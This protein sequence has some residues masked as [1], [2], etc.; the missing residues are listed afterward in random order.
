ML[1]IIIP[2]AGRGSRFAVAGYSDPKPL[3]PIN[4]TPMIQVVINNLRPVRPHRFIFIC[5][6]DH[7]EAYDLE[8]LLSACAPGC[9]V[10]RIEGLTEGA[11]CTVLAAESY[12]DESPLMIANSDQYISVSIDEYLRET[13]KGLDGLIMTMTADDPKWSF[14]GMRD[15]GLVTTVVEKQVISSEATVGIYNFARGRDFVDGAKRMIKKNQRVNGE[16]YVAPVY[17]E[18]IQ[19]GARIGIMNIGTD[20][21]GMYGLGTPSDLDFFLSQPVSRTICVAK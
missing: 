5:Q 4:G 14:V 7:V 16:F 20:T 19:N 15:D 8:N 6:R 10:V 9:S 17:N 18:L 3:I 1:N 13:D 21:D 2:M 12:I 11:A